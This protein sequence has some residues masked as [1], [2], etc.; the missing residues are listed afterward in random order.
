MIEFEV[1]D[2]TCGHCAGTI[3]A[4]VQK[5]APDATIEIDLPSHSV[6][7][8]GAA[9]AALVERTIREAGYTPQIKSR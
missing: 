8:D 1:K 6:R 3:T 7:V 9:D 2:M 5:T 4:A